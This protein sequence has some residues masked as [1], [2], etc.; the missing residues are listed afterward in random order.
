MRELE[1]FSPFPRRKG[2]R[3]DRSYTTVEAWLLYS[4]KERT[5]DGLNTPRA[6]SATGPFIVRS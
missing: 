6:T 3:G 2:G 5:N 1:K 4:P